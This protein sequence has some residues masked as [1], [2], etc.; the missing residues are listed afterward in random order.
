MIPNKGDDKLKEKGEM[1]AQQRRILF[2]MTDPQLSKKSEAGGLS[3][4]GQKNDAITYRY[5]N[6]TIK[7][8]GLLSLL[9][10]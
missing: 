8:E 6:D 2:G 9:S 5:Y 10:T 3:A 7:N 1:V 4:M